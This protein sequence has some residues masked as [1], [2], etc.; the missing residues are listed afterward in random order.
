MVEL[1][2]AFPRP[3][4]WRDEHPFYLMIVLDDGRYVEQDLAEPGWIAKLGEAGFMRQPG[5]W[6]LVRKAGGTIALML[7]VHDGEQP[8]YVARHVGFTNTG[9]GFETTVY[10]IGKKRLDGH[11][12]RLWLMSNGCVVAGDD[13]D[14]VALDLLKKGLMPDW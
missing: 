6:Y 13:I 12:D 3:A 9:G 4:R 8:Y 14:P 7:L 2:E 1:V 11:V 5:R 10:G